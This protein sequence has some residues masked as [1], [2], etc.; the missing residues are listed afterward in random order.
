[1][2]K[3]KI[4]PDNSAQIARQEEDRRQLDIQRGADA[5]NATFDETFTPDF[6]NQ[7]SQGVIGANLPELDRQFT[8]ANRVLQS[9]LDSRGILESSAGARQL[10]DLLRRNESVRTDL[11]N[12]AEN[13]EN[14]FR[15][16]VER[17]R[18]DLLSQ[19]LIAADPSQARTSALSASGAL[20]P[21]APTVTLGDVFADI[22]RTAGNAIVFDSV[23]PRRSSGLLFGSP[24]ES[25][26]VVGG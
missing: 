13:T 3:P 14:Q 17:T 2:C 16:D 26:Q 25:V 7:I 11:A 24:T 4:E 20:K 21:D 18:S 6:F 23:Q 15:S 10:A 1:M 9:R 5:I 19:N 8:D 22:L 12:E